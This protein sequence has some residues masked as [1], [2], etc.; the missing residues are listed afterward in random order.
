MSGPGTPTGET[1]RRAFLA[2]VIVGLPTMAVGAAYALAHERQT[3]P[4]ELSRWVVGS[5]LVHDL[6]FAPIMVAI[7]WAVNRLAP[8]WLRTPA[9]WA[10]ATTIMLSLFAWP[11]IRGYGRNPGVPS[12]LNRNYAAGLAWYVAA[13]WTVAAGWALVRFRSSRAPSRVA[14]PAEFEAPAA[15]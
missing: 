1:H 6:A 8:R 14:K 3:R 11:F 5:D 2:G 12:L 7:A 10:I 4:L 9:I 13:V 15:T